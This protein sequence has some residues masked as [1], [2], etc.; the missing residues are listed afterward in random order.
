MNT[1]NLKDL[2]RQDQAGSPD[3]IVEQ[4]LQQAFVSKA[5]SYRIHYNS[6]AS[7]FSWLFSPKQL[8]TKLAVTMIL[9]VFALVKPA[10]RLGS[11]FPVAADSTYVDKSY[12]L[13]SAMLTI[14][15]DTT[16]KR[17]F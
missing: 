15:K 4:R 2:I 5:S 16:G 1:T 17:L 14:P 3:P 10:T 6:F 13:D 12:V 9:L 8:G 7:F 11:G